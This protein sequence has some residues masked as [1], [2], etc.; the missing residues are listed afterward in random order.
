MKS[1]S[2]ENIR[3]LF[4]DLS[5]SI[6]YFRHTIIYLREGLTIIAILCFLI[7]GSSIYGISTF[8][9]LAIISYFFLNLVKNN[10]VSR[11]AKQILD[12][13]VKNY[14]KNTKCN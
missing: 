8:V 6:E 2:A 7:I 12:L 9:L 3:I 4:Q 11:A 13:Q 14:S 1:N 10:R 5:Q